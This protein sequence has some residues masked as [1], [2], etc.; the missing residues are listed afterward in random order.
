MSSNVTLRVEGTIA[1]FKSKKRKGIIAFNAAVV[2]SKYHCSF[3]LFNAI[4]IGERQRT[5]KIY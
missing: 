3:P 5:N 4:P 2:F 1:T